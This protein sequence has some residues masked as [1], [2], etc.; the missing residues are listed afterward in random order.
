MS[1]FGT[2]PRLSSSSE[3][4]FKE[5]LHVDL[6]HETKRELTVQLMFFPKKYLELQITDEKDY[7]F[8]YT[9]QLTENDFQIL[10]KDQAITID[11]GTFP[12]VLVELLQ[13]CLNGTRQCLMNVK[14]STFSIGEPQK[15]RFL[16]HIT[17][18]LKPAND[19]TLKK[20]LAERADE[21]KV[22]I[23]LI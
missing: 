2:I 1:L 6:D 10:K 15:M 11:F 19:S 17:L 22:G 14:D 12:S 21:F 13:N 3:L 23:V 18:Q 20:Y 7:F 16:H 4:L 8:L 5:S 9:L